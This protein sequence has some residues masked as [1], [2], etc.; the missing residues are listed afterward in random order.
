MMPRRPHALVEPGQLSAIAVEA[1][2]DSTVQS[3]LLDLGYAIF[4]RRQ[5]T[6]DTLGAIVK[7]GAERWWPV[8]KE[9]GLKAE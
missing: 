6:P 3:R 4:P 9:L 8:I 7:A 5:Q 1:F 2:A